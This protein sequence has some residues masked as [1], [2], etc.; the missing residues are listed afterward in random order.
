MGKTD[1]LNIPVVEHI[2]PFPNFG[3]VLL[4]HAR[5][6]PDKPALIFEGKA[7]TYL[8]LLK[9]CLTY[10]IEKD[11]EYEV[12]LNH[13][14]DNIIL[15]LAL[16][17]QGSAFKLN[18]LKSGTYIREESTKGF[19]DIDYFDPPYVRLDDKAFTL[20]GKY[21]FS[22][23]HVLVAAQAVGKAF[24]LFREGAAYCPQSVFGIEDL[25]FGILAPLYFAKSIY[26]YDVKTPDLFQYAWNGV[27]KS[28][29][30]DAVMV[31]NE[32][33]YHENVYRLV[34]SF[35]QA[36]G[37]GEVKGRDGN[38]VEFLGFEIEHGEPKGHCLGIEI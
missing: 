25:T 16:L 23:Y 21:E 5:E 14:Q 33:N 29:L 1:Y 38:A 17:T 10:K 24:K 12:E 37:L 35:E 4:Q 36:L 31:T 20:K 26:F 15:I 8:E 2:V 13:V 22:Q 3:S 32:V 7:Y 11:I 27:I 18:F 19:T 34:N 6:F 30:R 28:N 9:E